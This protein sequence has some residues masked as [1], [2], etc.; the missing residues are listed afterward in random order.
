MSSSVQQLSNICGAFS[1]ASVREGDFKCP[2]WTL[3]GVPLGWEV[4]CPRGYWASPGVLEEAVERH[5]CIFR[6]ILVV[7]R[8]ES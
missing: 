4:W 1:A 5:S 2:P 8:C 6:V 3:G 7:L